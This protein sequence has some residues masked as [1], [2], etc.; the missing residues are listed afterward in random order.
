MAGWCGPVWRGTVGRLLLE[1]I[2]R[3]KLLKLHRD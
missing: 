2:E 1:L 3:G